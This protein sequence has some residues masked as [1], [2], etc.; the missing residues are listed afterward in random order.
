VEQEKPKSSPRLIDIIASMLNSCM[1]MGRP[2]GLNF[3]SVLAVAHVQIQN[4]DWC[5]N[6]FDTV[7]LIQ[8]QPHI[9]GI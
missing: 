7:E 5:L 1:I 4:S 6:V 9:E 2:R 3:G 8:F